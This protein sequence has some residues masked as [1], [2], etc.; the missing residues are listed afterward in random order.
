MKLRFA[1]ANDFIVIN[2]NGFELG[3]DIRKSTKNRP[4]QFVHMFIHV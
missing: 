4:I 3:K 2:L 1:A